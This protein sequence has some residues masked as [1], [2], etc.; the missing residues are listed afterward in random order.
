MNSFQEAKEKHNYYQVKLANADEQLKNAINEWRQYKLAVKKSH[1]RQSHSEHIKE[2][3]K[4]DYW[5]M[6]SKLRI[7]EVRKNFFANKVE[8]YAEI[9]KK[10]GWT[11]AGVWKL[12]R[13]NETLL[14][15]FPDM[16]K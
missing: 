4:K 6:L 2:I 9:H 13:A 1:Y 3:L 15:A 14:E 10:K 8:Y 7:Y 16:F 12:R 11:D 5:A